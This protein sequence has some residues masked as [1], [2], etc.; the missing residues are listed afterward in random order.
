ML[1][2]IFNPFEESISD[3]LNKKLKLNK[4]V[5]ISILKEIYNGSFKGN[6]GDFQTDPNVLSEANIKD[7]ESSFKSIIKEIKQ[8]I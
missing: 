3:L 6:C 2:Y 8:S 4:T 1:K 7:L 5:L